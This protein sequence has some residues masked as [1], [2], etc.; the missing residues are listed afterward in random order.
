[1]GPGFVVGC[2]VLG[3]KYLKSEACEGIY[4]NQGS[5]VFVPWGHLAVPLCYS[6]ADKKVTVPEYVHFL[7]VPVIAKELAS[8]VKA[9]ALKA[10]DTVICGHLRPLTASMWRARLAGWQLFCKDH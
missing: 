5:T 1:M 6:P 2:F 3:D 10:M 9:E 8:A 7:H 4:M